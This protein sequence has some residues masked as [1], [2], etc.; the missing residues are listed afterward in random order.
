MHDSNLYWCALNLIS[1]VTGCF[2]IP[3]FSSLVG[4]PIGITSSAIELKICA[5][6]VGIKNYKTPIKKKKHDKIAL[7]AKTKLNCIEALISKSLIVSY[8]SHDGFVLV[9]NV[10]K[11]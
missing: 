5:I 3:D 8:I 11:E 9:N 6:T 2:S 10:L 7:L 4:I 1:A